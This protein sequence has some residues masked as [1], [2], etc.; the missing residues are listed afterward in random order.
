VFRQRAV[1]RSFVVARPRWS[2]RR[3]LGTTRAAVGAAQVGWC[4]RPVGSHVE[5]RT[6]P[7]VL[8][9][10]RRSKRRTRNDLPFLHR[11]TE[12]LDRPRGNT[13]GREW[14]SHRRGEARIV[15]CGCECAILPSEFDRRGQRRDLPRSPLLPVRR[16]SYRTRSMTQ[17]ADTDSR[18]ATAASRKEEGGRSFE[19]AK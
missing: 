16:R 13:A 10:R 4:Q 11:S 17:R 3:R 9:I 2:V 12:S 1:P 18:E 5:S 14:C 19:P 15:C 6:T 7:G 8:R